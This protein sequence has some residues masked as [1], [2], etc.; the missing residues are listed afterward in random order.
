[1]SSKRYNRTSRVYGKVVL[2]V[3]ATNNL[4]VG[5]TLGVAVTTNATSPTFN[6][7]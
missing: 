1:M 7:T 3:P 4:D 2:T 5:E 6:G